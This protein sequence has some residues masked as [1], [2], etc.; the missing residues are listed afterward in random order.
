[1]LSPSQMKNPYA[2]LLS[3]AFLLFGAQTAIHGATVQGRIEP[4]EA[5]DA[6]GQWRR[7]GTM[8]W[9]NHNDEITVTFSGNPINV[10]FEF[11]DIFGFNTPANHTLEVN[12]DGF[13]SFTG[14]YELDAPDL[15]IQSIVQD[16]DSSTA[17]DWEKSVTFT[18]TIV[19]DGGNPISVHLWKL[20]TPSWMVLFSPVKATATES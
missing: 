8:G 2:G 14:I 10:E 12:D 6:G 16:P 17:V 1:M 19:D 4:D 7:V 18:V 5:I 3:T 20:L 15:T 9:L 11:R 13:F